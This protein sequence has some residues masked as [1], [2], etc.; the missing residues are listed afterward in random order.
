MGCPWAAYKWAR[1]RSPNAVPS[2][3]CDATSKDLAPAF[4]F[5]PITCEAIDTEVEVG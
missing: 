3:S 1:A 2:L 4:V 5:S